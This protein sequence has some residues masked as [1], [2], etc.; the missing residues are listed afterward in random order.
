[1][2]GIYDLRRRIKMGKFW[3]LMNT[4]VDF[5][6]KSKDDELQFFIAPTG[7]MFKQMNLKEAK[8]EVNTIKQIVNV[9][10]KLIG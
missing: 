1:M 4:P 7:Y 5:V 2:Q 8:K 9:D 10:Y 6:L 3:D